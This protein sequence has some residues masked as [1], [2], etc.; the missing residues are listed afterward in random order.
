MVTKFNYM[1][2]C[3]SLRGGLQVVPGGS[4]FGLVVLMSL[5]HVGFPSGVGLVTLFCLVSWNASFSRQGVCLF[6]GLLDN[7]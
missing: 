5:Q 2:V 3:P 1:V 4:L 6:C 7:Y